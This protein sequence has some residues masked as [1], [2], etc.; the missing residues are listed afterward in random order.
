VGDCYF[1]RNI[2]IYVETSS[3]LIGDINLDGIIN[4]IDIVQL[5]AIILETVDINDFPNSDANQ[6][7][8]VDV[9]DI[10]Y[11]MNIILEQ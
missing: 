6:D 9:I 3:F 8:V 2:N 4:V 5:I 1:K 10:V 7:G 11:V